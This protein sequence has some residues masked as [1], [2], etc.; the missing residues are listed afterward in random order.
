VSGQALQETDLLEA[1]VV[2]GLGE[3]SQDDDDD[4]IK[5][6]P[7]TQKR[8]KISLKDAIN[9]A[10]LAVESARVEDKKGKSAAMCVYFT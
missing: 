3:N 5:H 10:A 9:N 4:G 8:G 6:K 2:D 1:N 7:K